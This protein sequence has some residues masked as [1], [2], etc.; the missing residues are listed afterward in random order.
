MSL[1]ASPQLCPTQRYA[2]GDCPRGLIQSPGNQWPMANPPVSSIHCNGKKRE[3]KR[4]SVKPFSIP[5]RCMC[6]C[7]QAC[8]HVCVYVLQYLLP[9]CVI[10]MCKRD[11]KH[12]L[13]LRT[14]TPLSKGRLLCIPNTN[15]KPVAL[16]DTVG[17]KNHA[18]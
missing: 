16:S 5:S 10:W 12:V 9:V 6:V 2:K 7:V 3:N 15:H 17:L 11:I 1:L 4:G 8:M 13:Q 18:D 14:T